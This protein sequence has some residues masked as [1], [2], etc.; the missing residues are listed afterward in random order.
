MFNLRWALEARKQDSRKWE[1]GTE[2][3]S[4][5][6]VEGTL[7]SGF[8]GRVCVCESTLAL[9]DYLATLN[10]V[11]LLPEVPEEIC[12]K[13]ILR[14]SRALFIAK[15]TDAKSAGSLSWG[16]LLQIHLEYF[17]LP[18]KHCF[19]GVC[20][21]LWSHFVW[22]YLIVPH[23]GSVYLLTH[24]TPAPL[25]CCLFDLFINREKKIPL[26]V[27]HILCPVKMFRDHSRKHIVLISQSVGSI[28]SLTN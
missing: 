17:P 3:E 9:S 8:A 24:Q 18:I 14:V 12:P 26:R 21:C 16:P 25:W 27:K 2:Q 22:D 4:M 19:C 13:C 6:P 11:I 1:Q 28:S 20:I 23:A 15:G 5:V 10:P 7:C